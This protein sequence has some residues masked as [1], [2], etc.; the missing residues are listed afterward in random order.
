MSKESDNVN[1]H[2]IERVVRQSQPNDKHWW[3][4]NDLRHAREPVDS[5]LNH[6]LHLGCS[7]PD[8]AVG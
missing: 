8:E 5:W 2:S 1:W 6:Q 7:E 3:C 4:I